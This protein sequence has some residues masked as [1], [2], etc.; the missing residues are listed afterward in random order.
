MRDRDIPV[1]LM[2]SVG[3]A[4]FERLSTGVYDFAGHWDADD[5]E[6]EAMGCRQR[7]L[8]Q[9]RQIQPRE[10]APLV[11]K[12]RREKL[13]IRYLSRRGGGLARNMGAIL[14]RVQHC[15]ISWISRCRRRA[16]RDGSR[17]RY[18]GSVRRVFC[19]RN[20]T[21]ER[22]NPRANALQKGAQRGQVGAHGS[23]QFAS[24]ASDRSRV[25]LPFRGRDFSRLWPKGKF[26]S[27]ASESAC[28]EHSGLIMVRH[29]S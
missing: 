5:A 12:V 8:Y 18:M 9:R 11:V 15:S 21:V 7:V 10:V 27:A 3:G 19:R 20:H 26:A 22:I 29:N 28:G 4:T 14:P 6:W 25:W 17:T 13:S 2:V 23:S 1:R 24:K 16:R